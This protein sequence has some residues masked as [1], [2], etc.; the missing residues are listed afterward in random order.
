MSEETKVFESTVDSLFKGMDAFLSTKTVV[1]KPIEIGGTIIIPL[2]DVSFG[3]GA[4]VFTQEKKNT[5]GGG[6]G[7]KMVPSAV[8]VIHDGM[9]RLINISTH[10]GMDKLLDIMPDFVDGFRAKL[11]KKSTSNDAAR[12]EAAKAVEDAVIDAAE[13]ITTDE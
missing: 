1:G 7:G 10:S 12:R 9:T 11:G 2:I 6:L 5:G 3:V 8:L 4:G 13:D